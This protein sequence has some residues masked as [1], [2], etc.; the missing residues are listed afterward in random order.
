MF[1]SCLRNLY[2]EPRL[3]RRGFSFIERYNLI[4]ILLAYVTKKPVVLFTERPDIPNKN[5]LEIT[6][7]LLKIPLCSP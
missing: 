5:L 2:T 1:E 6:H 4:V 3:N 7:H